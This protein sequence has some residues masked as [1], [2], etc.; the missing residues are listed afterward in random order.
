MADKGFIRGDVVT[1]YAVS[2][3]GPGASF[4]EHRG[5]VRV[6]RTDS[7]EVLSDESKL[8]YIVPSR[9]CAL[10]ARGGDLLE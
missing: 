1:F 8:W 7:V 10:H 2:G 4:R 6:A 3:N 5:I 9:R